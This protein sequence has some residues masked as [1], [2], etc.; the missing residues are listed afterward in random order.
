MSEKYCL[1]FNINTAIL[2][3]T[4]LFH[5]NLFCYNT[6]ETLKLFGNHSISILL[7]CFEIALAPASQQ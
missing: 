6:E 4:V 1:I 5:L 3:F 7:T 2:N